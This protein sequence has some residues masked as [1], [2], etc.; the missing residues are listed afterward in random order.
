M[1]LLSILLAAAACVTL[2]AAFVIVSAFLTTKTSR[3]MHSMFVHGQVVGRIRNG[4]Y[5]VETEPGRFLEARET[6]QR[7]VPAGSNVAVLLTRYGYLF[8]HP[9]AQ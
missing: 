7:H 1:N 4:W 5:L 3:S 2:S 9:A 6:N 8:Q